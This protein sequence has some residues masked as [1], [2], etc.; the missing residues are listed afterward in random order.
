A[1]RALE[2]REPPLDGPEDR[3]VTAQQSRSG[4]PTSLAPDGAGEPIDDDR[5]G[6]QVQIIVRG[7]I[8]AGRW[9]KRAKQPGRFPFSQPSAHAMFKGIS[10]LHGRDSGLGIGDS[11]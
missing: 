4:A 1:F 5:V 9:P 3:S 7:K 8:E 10:R 2:V 11:S 6:R